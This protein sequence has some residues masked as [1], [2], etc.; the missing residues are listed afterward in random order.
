M[1]GQ[2]YTTLLAATQRAACQVGTAIG[3]AGGAAL[4]GLSATSLIGGAAAGTAIAVFAHVATSGKD[5]VPKQMIEE[6]KA[7]K[8]G[9]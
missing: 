4:A 7:I 9:V 1:P 6:V 5:A 8:D 3:A 2:R